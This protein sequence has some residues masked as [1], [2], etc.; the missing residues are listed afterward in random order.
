MGRNRPRT[1]QNRSIQPLPCVHPG[2]EAV[3]ADSAMAFGRHMHL[4]FGLGV[5]EHGAQRSASGRGPVEAGAGDTITVNPGE[6]HDGTPLGDGGRA[7]RMLYLEPAL[8]ANLAADVL[9][10][11]CTAFEFHAPALRDAR[12]A[13]QVRALFAAATA[14]AAPSVDVRVQE[15]LLSVLG[16]LLRPRPH[17]HPAAIAPARAMMDDDPATPWSLEQLAAEAGLSR[18]QLVRHFARATGLT[19]HAYLLQQRLQHARRLMAGGTPLAEA[20]ITSGFADQSH[21][22]RVFSRSFGMTPGAYARAAIS[23]KTTAQP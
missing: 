19:P 9:P 1:M 23:F 13:A 15:C 7:W 5:I 10:G 14:P 17:E 12:L 2:I 18:Y 8:V 22:T 3:Q 20:A 4:Q 16:A 21:L 11:T 6:V